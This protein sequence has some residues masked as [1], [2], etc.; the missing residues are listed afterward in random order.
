MSERP[1]NNPLQS[2]RSIF[3]LCVLG[4]LVLASYAVARP[5]V[6]SLFLS[7]YSSADLPKV[8]IAVAIGA[9]LT[10]AVYNRFAASRDLIQVF[11]VSVL[12]SMGSLLVLLGLKQVSE[13]LATFLMYVWK[14]IYIVVLVETFWSLANTLFRTKQATNLYGIFCVAG[15]LGGMSANLAIG[16]LAKAYG[17]ETALLTIFPILGLVWLMVGTVEKIP[18]PVDVPAAVPDSK[19]KKG[20]SMRE[21]ME[22]L[23]KSPYLVYMLV[24]ICV[25]QVVITLV[26]YQFNAVLE[27]SYPDTDARTAAIGKVYATIDMGS[28]T[29]QLLAGPII[30]ALGV[31]RVL[32]MIP[33]LVGAAVAGFALF[34]TFAVIAAAKVS[35]K[36][37]DYSLFRAAKEMLYIPLSYAE[38]T[39][40]KA[41]VDIL[42]YR[43][44]KGGASLLLMGIIAIS[45]GGWV[46]WLC[47]ALVVGWL[48]VTSGIVKR[49]GAFTEK[50]EQSKEQVPEIQSENG[51]S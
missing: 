28:L 6:E 13:E 4:Y 20:S 49:Y 10:V 12:I 24:L 26:D 18:G 19:S 36:C 23:K 32:L 3:L 9:L 45:L 16:P 46:A 31:A 2:P 25:V 1:E 40:G 17:T 30:K 51:E 37:F 21:G 15:S 44:A 34:P 5:S 43:V 8:W 27:E 7:V 11:R 47:L 41:V 39:Q 14:D 50:V 35:G 38:K 42:T 22:V 29:L 48:A 33:L